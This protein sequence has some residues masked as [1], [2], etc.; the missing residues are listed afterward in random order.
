MYQTEIDKLLN[1]DVDS[2]NVTD[3]DVERFTN[4]F[5][6]TL[7]ISANSCIPDGKYRPY[8]KPYWKRNR[9]Q[10][11]HYEQ[12]KA[13]RIWKEQNKHRDKMEVK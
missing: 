12:R 1:F 7:H 6:S 4:I 5:I 13:R 9:L 2:T 10:D 8:L 3:Y 11:F